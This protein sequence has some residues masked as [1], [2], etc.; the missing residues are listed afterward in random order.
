MK[1]I[2]YIFW[3]VLFSIYNACFAEINIT[4][5]SD[6]TSIDISELVELRIDV[7]ATENE[8]IWDLQIAGIENFNVVWQSVNNA[9]RI[10]N[11]ERSENYTLILTLKANTAWE[12]AI[13]PVKV[14]E[15]TSNILNLEVTWADISIGWQQDIAVWNR[16][17][18]WGG[19]VQTVQDNDEVDQSEQEPE[20]QVSDEQ[21]LQEYNDMK[22]GTGEISGLM[23]NT[24]ISPIDIQK[25]IFAIILLIAIFLAYKF[26]SVLKSSPLL[27]PKPAPIIVVRTDYY[28]LLEKIE[29]VYLKAEKNIFYMQLSNL[30]R[31]YMDERV[32]PWLSTKTLTQV[33]SKLQKN[34]QL[35][36]LYETIYYPEYNKAKDTPEQRLDILESLKQELQ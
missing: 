17:I 13:G 7:V 20:M 6:S 32:A 1:K 12:Y 5:N 26:Y 22:S 34:T 31:R 27:K 3:I 29:D 35:Y 23:E 8:T 4:I 36:K 10:M 21:L 24:Q 25:T 14:W 9:T 15:I 11:W 2:L 28:D 16:W 18:T 19:G 33:R 30:L